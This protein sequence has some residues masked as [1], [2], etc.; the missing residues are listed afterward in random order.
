ITDVVLPGMN[1]RALA[2][3]VQAIRPGIRVLYTSGYSENVMVHHGVLDPGIEFIAK[4][5]PIELLAHRVR[6]V[7]DRPS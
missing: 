6:E 2:E 1:G 7:L 3:A 5:Y 4:P